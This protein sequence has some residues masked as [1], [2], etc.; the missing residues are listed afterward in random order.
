MTAP[1][2]VAAERGEADGLV[3]RFDHVAVAVPDIADAIPLYHGL[4]GG[5]LIA[6]GDDERLGLRTVQLRF[7]PGTKI[8]LLAP[9]HEDSYL[10][11]YLR[12]HGP[13]F[14]HMTCFVDD[15]ARAVAELERAG[16]ETVDTSAADEFWQET[17]VR[18]SSGFGTLIQLARSTLEWTTPVMPAGAT[19]DDVVAGR[20][21]WNEA[22]PRWREDR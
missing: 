9:L 6:G 22:R 8:E 1:T 11:A 13:G 15:V 17:F 19:I 21:L 3:T 12:K 10:A 2:S 18:P 16:Y 7:D 20:I 4:L 14:H 5:K